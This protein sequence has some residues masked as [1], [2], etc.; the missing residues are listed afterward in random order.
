MTVRVEVNLHYT[1]FLANQTLST[2]KMSLPLLLATVQQEKH[3]E[4]S[5]SC[6]VAHP[7]QS[8]TTT[9]AQ[10]I[11]RVCGWGYLFVNQWQTGDLETCMKTVIVY[12][13]DA[14]GGEIMHFTFK[15]PKQNILWTWKAQKA[16]C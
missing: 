8:N 15:H 11:A 16:C 6:G 14:S 1:D 13:G 5:T 4:C 7:Y 12:F 3:L 9:L 2:I 10:P